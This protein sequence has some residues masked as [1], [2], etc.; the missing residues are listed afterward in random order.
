MFFE[1]PNWYQFSD[2]TSLAAK[3]QK[4][5]VFFDILGQNVNQTSIFIEWIESRLLPVGGRGTG[6][7][8]HGFLHFGFG[9]LQY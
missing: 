9:K 1:V 2:T 3:C 8:T 4:S 6:P 5:H 7:Q